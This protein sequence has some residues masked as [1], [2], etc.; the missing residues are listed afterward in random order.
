MK[1]SDVHVVADANDGVRASF[2]ADD[3]VRHPRQLNHTFY[4]ACHVLGTSRRAADYA[5]ALA[6]VY[7]CLPSVSATSRKCVAFR[8]AISRRMRAQRSHTTA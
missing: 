1:T 3:A 5:R 8:T 2:E 6:I 4:F 7:P